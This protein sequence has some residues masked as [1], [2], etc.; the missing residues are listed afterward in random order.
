[1]RHDVRCGEPVGDVAGV[2]YSEGRGKRGSWDAQH[3]PCVHKKMK[4][5]LEVRFQQCLLVP[6]DSCG[7]PEHL[8]ARRGYVEL[9]PVVGIFN[10]TV[11]AQLFHRSP[12]RTGINCFLCRRL[13]RK[14]RGSAAE[15]TSTPACH[16]PCRCC[17]GCI[18]YPDVVF[19]AGPN[20]RAYV[21]VVN[22]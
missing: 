12:S 9:V 20:A 14:V 17:P 5:L 22:G 7:P 1:M 10:Q 8:L 21:N 13:S 4:E 19:E 6:H 15:E 2:V 3:P 11:C 16:Y 18:C